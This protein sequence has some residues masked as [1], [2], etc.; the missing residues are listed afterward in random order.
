[1]NRTLSSPPLHPS[2]AVPFYYLSPL[3]SSSVF[4]FSVL[5]CPLLYHYPLFIF[6]LFCLFFLF[7]LVLGVSTQMH[8]NEMIRK[9]EVC[10]LPAR[11]IV[12]MKCSVLFWAFSRRTPCASYSKNERTPNS[13]NLAM[14]VRMYKKE[15]L[16]DNNDIS[17]TDRKH[18]EN[19]VLVRVKSRLQLRQRFV[20]RP[21][22]CKGMRVKFVKSLVWCAFKILT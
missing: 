22:S 13:Q 10:L 21:D 4:G 1:M 7:P 16:C 5:V 9:C 20:L 11:W 8:T 12:W 15:W 6:S 17:D 19:D 14:I 3:F 2:Q 18:K